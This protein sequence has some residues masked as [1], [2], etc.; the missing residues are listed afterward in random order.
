MSERGGPWSP[1]D[2]SPPPAPRR[3]LLLWVVAL[4]AIL[5]GVRLLYAA[6]PG[7]IS[8]PQDWAWVGWGV[9]M[10]GLFSTSLL[11]RNIRWREFARHA[12]IWAG[13]VAVLLL[14]VTYR[15]ELA[16]VGQRVRMQVS[17]SYPVALSPHELV[18]TQGDDGGFLV[19]GE[20]NGKRVRFLVDTGASDVVLSPADARRIG[21]DT[22]KLAFDRPS[23]TAN[24]VGYGAAHKVDRLSVGAIA[25]A[26]V[27]VMV[28]QA[29]MSSSLLGMTFLRRLESFQIKG[30]KLY[31]T[32]KD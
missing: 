6:F 20:V 3:R 12:G 24:G 23:E 11:R 5:G 17:S 27:P 21:I 4:L 16:G 25:F 9:L 7:A 13:I 29:P 30:D 18:V 10:M 32:S 19:M 2:Q 15:H 8:T 1:E 26:D 31:L 28:N 22:A 14:G